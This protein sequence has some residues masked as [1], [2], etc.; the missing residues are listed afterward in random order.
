VYAAN[1]GGEGNLVPFATGGPIHDPSY[2]KST[3]PEAAGA[4]KTGALVMLSDE[5]SGL[6]TGYGTWAVTAAAAS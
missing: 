2:P 3:E 6:H 4:A 5:A 1:L